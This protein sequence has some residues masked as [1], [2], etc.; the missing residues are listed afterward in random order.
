MAKLRIIFLTRSG[1][2]EYIP[3]LGKVFRRI[4]EFIFEMQNLI[5]FNNNSLILQQFFHH[6]LTSEMLLTGK[7]TVSVYHP[8]R[9]YVCGQC[10]T[11]VHGPSYHSGRPL[12]PEVF[13]YSTIG[14]YAAIRYFLH[15]RINFIKEA[16]ML[17]HDS[18]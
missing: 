13:C 11:S 10:V 2:K 1:F 16:C 5:I 8:V 18:I 15:H 17:T 9:R 12:T 4:P 6:I 7:H 3:Y 14:R